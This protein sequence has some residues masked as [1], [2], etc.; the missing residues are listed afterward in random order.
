MDNLTHSLVG[1]AAAKAGLERLSP[2]TTAL[3]VI[4]ANAPDLDILTVFNGRWAYLQHHRGITHSIIGTIA[5]AVVIPILFWLGDQF[6]SP[7]V[8]RQPKT[9]LRGL[10]LASL[11]V[12]AT[13]PI[14][15]WTNNY[16]IRPLL[17]WN[18]QWY[19][20]DLVFIIDPWL[21]LSLGGVC[22]LLTS[23]T[24]WQVGAWSL[25]ATILS[26]AVILVPSLRPG[27]MFPVTAQIVWV[28]GIALLIAV[29]RARLAERWPMAIPLTVFAMIVVYWGGLA[30]LHRSAL[31][32]AETEAVIQ[33]SSRGETINRLAAMPVLANP[34]RWQC[35]FVTNHATYRFDLSLVQSNVISGIVRYEKPEGSAAE[36]FSSAARDPRTSIFLGFAR[37]PVMRVRGDCLSETLV[38][39]A[40]LRYTEPGTGP[41]GAFTLDV[42]IECPNL[43]GVLE[44][45]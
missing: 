9:K 3:C 5:L 43:T 10:L 14:L 28:L 44:E 38:Q 19:Y 39:F 12:S 29:H 11:V 45:K 6:I 25:L 8:G 34:T 36:A 40:D 33:A 1:L 30:I 20:G 15:D 32:Q 4:A 22:F 35:V 7:L 21:W 13:H 42:P 41:R 18:G 31:V 23:K 26:A 17:P 2:G 27:S 16:G 37:F 24:R